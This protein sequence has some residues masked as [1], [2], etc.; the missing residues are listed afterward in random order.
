MAVLAHI[1]GFYI[2]LFDICL[3]DCVDCSYF[4]DEVYGEELA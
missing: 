1:L 3:F 4:C 2:F